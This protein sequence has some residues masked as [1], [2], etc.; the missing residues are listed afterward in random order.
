[1]CRVEWADGRFEFA[2][3]DLTELLGCAHAS[4]LTR[5][6]AR[7]GRGRERKRTRY[8]DLIARKGDDHEK[9]YLGS[10]REEGRAVT[11]PANVAETA[12][13]MRQSADVIFQ[14][15]VRSG[16]WRGRADFLERVP[17]PS[18]LG[19]WS[20]EAVDTKLARTEL[21]AEHALQ[22]CFYSEAVGAVQGVPPQHAHIVLGTRQRESIRIREIAAYYRR[23]R[24]GLE[25]AAAEERPTEAYPC[26]ACVYCGYR[27]RCETEWRDT[28]HLSLVAGIRRD[29]VEEL[30]EAGVNTRA[31]LAAL[32]E[33]WDGLRQQAR[34]QVEADTVLTIPY[35]CLPLAA[36]R[37]F[38]RL[39]DP[40]PG[41]VMFDIEGDPVFTA[42][43]DLTFL[44]GLLLAEGGGW[45]Y[46]PIWAHDEAGERVALEQ[47]VDLIRERLASFP[48]MHVYHYSHAEPGVLQRLA[49]R[50]ATREYEVDD[51]L[52][53]KVLVDLYSVLRQA[54]RVGVESY[55]LKSIEKLTQFTRTAEVDSGADAVLAY[56]EWRGSRD[57]A[58]LEA[59]ARYNEEDCLAT[60]AVREWL[61]P[62]RPD[63]FPGPE[64]VT[65]P[66]RSDK[67]IAREQATI[68]L[69]EQLFESLEPIAPLMAELLEYHRREARPG[70][71]AFFERLELDDA[72]IIAASE[73]IGGLHPI[74]DRREVDNNNCEQDFTYPPQLHK[75]SPGDK[76]LDPATEKGFPLTAVDDDRCTLTLR[77]KALREGFPAALV[78]DGPFA[79]D[80][81]QEALLRVGTSIRDGS[82]AYPVLEEI[83][84]RR[85]PRFAGRA[86][87]EEIQTTKLEEQRALARSLDGSYLLVQGPP[88][89]G[90]TYTGA[91]LIVDLIRDHKVRVGVTALSHRAINNL[92]AEIEK[93][94]AEEGVTFRGA[95]RPSD[96]HEAGKVPDGGQIENVKGD[97][98][99]DPTYDVVAG[100]TWLYAAETAGNTLDYLVIDEAGQL[101]LADALA[102]GTAARNLILL[103]DP[104]QL[105]QVSQAIHPEG[106]SASVLEHLLGDDTTVPRNRGVFLEETWRMHPDV[107]DFISQEVYDG[108]LRSEEKCADQN[109]GAGTGIRYL[110]VHHRGNESQSREEAE[111]IR[112]VC[113]ALIGQSYTDR[114]GDTRPLVPDDLMVVSPYN[115]QVRLVRQR[116]PDG[117]RVGTVDAFQGQEAP[118]VIFSMATSTGEDIPRDVAFLFSR[119]RL[120]VAV[121]RA[122]CLAIVCCCPE[123]LET[124]ARTIEEMRLISTLCA[125]VE[126]AGDAP[127]PA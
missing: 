85:L 42:A 127:V 91:R 90:K 100:T 67:S 64:P 45:R 16:T 74:G 110:P 29:Q 46:L 126:Y 60:L 22:L 123:L 36:D 8:A 15:P 37:G 121:S 87:G 23:A 118:V 21:K 104:L 49:A 115:S 47:F 52:R 75:L 113:D 83:L 116:L 108:R 11:E 107:C 56:E 71:R 55:G 27:E 33:G 78:A 6:A 35:E 119:N 117:V 18:D 86:E 9:A 66:K 13:L 80:T 125:L 3:T 105:P 63:E 5:A 31:D 84:A 97:I 103:G 99:R 4:A 40:S 68:A 30:R 28:D 53:R 51:L 7:A 24:A 17:Y 2:P 10:L 43:A 50:H 62:Q 69:R 65:V 124:R 54:M 120:N 96:G 58:V 20:Y 76:V 38:A 26:P 106:T 44:F 102:A 19:E 70:W 101:S 59:I 32:T 92:L 39:P 77:A 112:L 109:T 34:L 114:D 12:E 82:H 122:R 94:A 98:C 89:T 79:M 93:A 111:A 88:G 48:D 1:M 73:A 81:Q 14:A 25:R 61:L 57:P 95:R 72:D 41:D